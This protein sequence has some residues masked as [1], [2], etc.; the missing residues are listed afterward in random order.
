MDIISNISSGLSLNSEVFASEFQENL[1]EIDTSSCKWLYKRSHYITV[2]AGQ[3]QGTDG[4]DQQ[5]QGDESG[6]TKT[7][8][9]LKGSMGERINKALA[10]VEEKKKKRAIRKAE[11]RRNTCL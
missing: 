6:D 8:T 10:K 4:G 5:D 2:F 7:G 3:K 1:E 9:T 11:V